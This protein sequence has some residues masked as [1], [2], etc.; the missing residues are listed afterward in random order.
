MSES[1]VTLPEEE[2]DNIYDGL[3]TL[4]VDQFNRA[5][6]YRTQA[7][8]MGKS[9][10]LWFSLL[11][12]AYH[13]I[14]EREE[15][16]ARPGMSSYFGLVQIKSNMTAS[17][18]R[19]KFVGNGDKVPFNIEPTPIVE[20]SK[21]LSDKAFEIVKMNLAMKLQEAGIP[22]QA[23]IQNGFI[24]PVIA[25]YVTKIA[26]ESKELQRNEEMKLATTATGKMKKKITDQLVEASY[27]KAMTD[28]LYDLALYPYAVIAYD[29]E[30]VENTKWSGN[31]YV[32]ERAAKPSF[33]RVS[34]QN[35]YF[36]PDATSAQDGEFVIEVMQRSRDEMLEFVGNKELGYVDD[37]IL[38]V[39]DNCIGNWAGLV[40]ESGSSVEFDDNIFTVL[41]CQT[42]VSGL[43]LCEYGCNVKEK[44][45][46][47]YFVADIEVIDRRVIRCQIVNHPLGERTYYSASYKRV[48]GSPYGISVGMMVYDRQLVVNRIQYAM[49][50]N[51]EYSSGPSFEVNSNAFDHVAD[52]SFRPYSK[53]Y[54]SPKDH[55]VVPVRMHQVQPTFLMQFNL[56]Q[57]QIRLADDECGL[58]AFLNGDTGLRGAGRTL[59]GLALINDNAV[60][61]LENCASNIDEFIIRPLIM[62]L[63]SRNMAS[64]DDEIKADAK[65]QATGLLGL[66]AEVDK[67]KALAGVVPQLGALREQGVV[68]DELYSGAIRDY[69]DSMG[70]PVDNYMPNAAAQFELN[71]AVTDKGVLDGRS[72]RQMNK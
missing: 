49:L 50:A 34:P 65:V 20:L 71:T 17:Y 32:R 62:L 14:H 7:M 12:Q 6:A 10:E 47:K 69:L 59:G 1:N 19:S 35:I 26:K 72:L 36:A 56:L 67:A 13:K 11:Y 18:L 5:R 58:P 41:K 66:K 37:A 9:V 4:V 48:A 27:S 15:L 45:F 57:N 30:I 44:D 60:L 64:G 23:I 68:P 21:R 53:F 2:L 29:N 40:D 16:E 25:N 24:N 28:L 38:D 31:K 42:L 3:A 33:R 43:E 54:S 61:G 55:S 52:V 39:I 46:N 8:V 51:S 63:Y 70:L 22:Q